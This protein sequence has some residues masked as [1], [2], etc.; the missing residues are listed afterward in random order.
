MTDIEVTND[1]VTKA[2]LIFNA[3]FMFFMSVCFFVGS[4]ELLRQLIDQ[5]KEKYSPYKNQIKI[6][7]YLLAIV[8]FRRRN[9]IGGFDLRLNRVN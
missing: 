9:K 7:F 6:F 8:F 5:D 2:H 4:K 1:V 3:L